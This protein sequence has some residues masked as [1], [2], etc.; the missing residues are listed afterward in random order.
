MPATHSRRSFV[1]ASLA[2]T[3]LAGCGFKMRGPQPLRFKT[4]HL[5]MDPY[6]PFAIQLRREIE[7]S[8]TTTIVA[9]PAEADVRLDIL[10]NERN[11]EILSL[12][13]AGTIREYQL[14][15][16]IVFRVLDRAGNERFPAT[17]LRARREY[18]FDD[19]QAIAKQREEIL[20]FNDME[21]DLL[22]QL[23][24]RLATVRP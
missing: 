21:R 16:T 6:S 12:S 3:A 23:M 22:Q 7:A 15:Q 13:G 18:D 1:L 24:R 8:G 19:A 5:G 14:D 9:T 11:R 4:I 20:L 17:A 10:R 2:M